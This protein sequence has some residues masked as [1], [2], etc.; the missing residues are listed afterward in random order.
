MADMRRKFFA[1]ASHPFGSGNTNPP[2]VCGLGEQN[3][4]V[5]AHIWRNPKNAMS[6]FVTIIRAALYYRQSSLKNFGSSLWQY[7]VC[8]CNQHRP[9]NGKAIERG[10][11]FNSDYF[12]PNKVGEHGSKFRFDQRPTRY[13]F[14]NDDGNFLTRLNAESIVFKTVITSFAY[15]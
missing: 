6:K 4:V 7:F 15:A 9:L 10:I 14:E 2:E 13:Y 12:R 1:V 5:H 8:R 11:H 3:C